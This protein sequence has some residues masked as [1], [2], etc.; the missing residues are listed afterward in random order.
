MKAIHA[1]GRDAIK[2]MRKKLQ[3]RMRVRARV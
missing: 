1:V 2:K 3:R